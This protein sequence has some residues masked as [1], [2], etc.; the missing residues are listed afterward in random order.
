MY[1]PGFLIGD[2]GYLRLCYY[3]VLILKEIIRKMLEK[4]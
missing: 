3:C 1:S 4:M 2:P